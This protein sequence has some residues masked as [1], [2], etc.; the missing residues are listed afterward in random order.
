MCYEGQKISAGA[1]KVCPKLLS[2]PARGDLM[3]GTKCSCSVQGT[4]FYKGTQAHITCHQNAALS[5]IVPETL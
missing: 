2:D 4:Y 3:V 5:L 1:E